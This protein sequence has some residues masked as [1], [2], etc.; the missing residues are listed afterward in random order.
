MINLKTKATVLI[1]SIVLSMSV[2]IFSFTVRANESSSF[3]KEKP[4]EIY[5]TLKDFSG[6]PT[7]FRSDSETP[8]LVLDVY[9]SELP[10][11]DR[12]RLS[13]GITAKTLEEILSMAENYE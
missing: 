4:Q 3:T 2:L 11:K 8:V 12:Q 9:T 7:V 5:Y 6:K 13:A 10:N 1:F